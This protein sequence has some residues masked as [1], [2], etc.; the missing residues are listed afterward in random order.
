MR[1]GLVLAL[2]AGLAAALA[3]PALAV[4][5]VRT[6]IYRALVGDEQVVRNIPALFGFHFCL[7]QEGLGHDANHRRLKIGEQQARQL[8]P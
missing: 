8:K 3:A 5:P 1:R 4:P 7:Q 2:V 6:T